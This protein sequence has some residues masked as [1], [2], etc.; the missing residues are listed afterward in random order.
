MVQLN[1]ALTPDIDSLNERIDK[2]TEQ[3]SNKMTELETLLQEKINL[4][5]KEINSLYCGIL[6]IS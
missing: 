1:T 6:C 4:Q 2:L 5:E 3:Q